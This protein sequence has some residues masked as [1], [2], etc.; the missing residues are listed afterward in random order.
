MDA[1]VQ[2]DAADDEDDE[3]ESVEVV[4]SERDRDPYGIVVLEE[5]DL[6]GVSL[7]FEEEDG[8]EER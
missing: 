5:S 8:E 1:G 6:Q 4:V 3:D 7:G 2:L